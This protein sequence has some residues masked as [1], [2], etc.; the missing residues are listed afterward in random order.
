M[1]NGKCSG[2]GTSRFPHPALCL[3]TGKLLCSWWRGCGAEGQ[4]GGLLH[5]AEL[6]GG[7]TLMLSLRSTKVRM[8]PAVRLHHHSF[9]FLPRAADT[10]MH[11]HCQLLQHFASTL[12]S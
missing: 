7:T 12:N 11:N 1:E 10:C 8:P 5:A 9:P 4:G 2:C 6:C 3:L